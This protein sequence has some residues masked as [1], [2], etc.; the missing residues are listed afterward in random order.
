MHLQPLDYAVITIFFLINIAI[1]IYYARRGGTSIGEFFLSG[2]SVPW[3]LAGTSMV[4]TTFAADTPLAVT[5]FVVKNGVAGNWLWWNMVMSGM[6][7]V[8]FFAALWRRSGVLTDVEFIELRY[9]GKPAAALRGVRAVYQGVI[10]NT[11]IMGWV[12]LAI[13]KILGL[14]LHIPKWE[15]ILVCLVLTGIYV[16]I[17]GLWSVLVTDLLQFIVKMTMAI[18]LAAAAVAAVG[19]IAT[20]KIHLA[21]I[22]AARHASAGGSVLAFFPTTNAA[23]MPLLS[24]LVFVSVSWWASSYPG[25]E[26]GGGGYI[27]QRIFASKNERHAIWATLFFNVAHYALRPWPWILVALAAL[28]LYPHGVA[29]PVT[30]KIDPELNY[31]QTMIDYL[32][33]SLRG[34]MMAGFLAA[35]MSTIGTQLNLGASYLTN[36]LYK[37]FWKTN[38][39]DAHYVWVSRA[40]TIVAM[41][42]AAIATYLMDSV[43]GAWAYI[44]TFTAGVG[45]VMILRWYWWR[46]NAWTEISAL[47]ASGIVASI[48]QRVI[49]ADNPNQTAIILL[50]T[51]PIT[52]I[53]WLTVTFLTKPEPYDTLARF[54]LKV[55]P[56]SLGWA[57]IAQRTGISS[58]G[59][60]LGLSVADWVAGCGLVYCT[61]FGIGKVILEE[62]A[63]GVSLLVAAGVCA[64][65]IFWDMNRRDWESIDPRPGAQRLR[66]GVIAAASIIVLFLSL[67]PSIVHA[68]AF[69]K[70]LENLHGDVWYTHAG[71]KQSMKI[72]P[73]A[74][75]VLHDSDIAHTGNN[76]MGNLTLPDSSRVTMASNS[77]VQLAF[78]NQTDAANARFV[79]YDGKTRFRIEHP[80]G[81][82]A[83]YIFATPTGQIAVRGTEGDISV[84]RDDGV[85]LNVYHL[86]EPDLPV[87][88]AMIN[89]QQY[90]I[91][92]GRKIWMR[93]DHGKLIARVTAL[94]TAEVN[95]F[96]E[97]GP[98][99]VIDGGPLTP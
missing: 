1:G 77:A 73:S 44:L 31:I 71:D 66:A 39:S 19:G 68:D 16:A 89:G 20:M 95:R 10:I 91:P 57:P 87:H 82:R 21:A 83:N 90:D 63:S 58:S 67:V 70:S 51:V 86:D 14:T 56:A 9:A 76:S 55:Q 42:L 54:Y 50:I 92:A 12:N 28:I 7:T 75:Q 98:P 59:S 4:A 47:L 22:D 69:N 11:V 85:R 37:R 96:S 88:V 25:A 78:F 45:L 65:F 74:S 99:S 13:A 43:G 41:I 80:K 17:G 81:G 53:V 72:A 3:W 49:P 34:L 97:L 52:T 29:D 48:L 24:F 26:P 32:P 38:Q 93:W 23:W 18:V 64:A 60:A 5:G 15:A 6:L 8:F 46:I 62:Y 94:T 79:I 33:A 30:G 40:M 84:S 61:L 36:D 2:R 27:A 35:Y